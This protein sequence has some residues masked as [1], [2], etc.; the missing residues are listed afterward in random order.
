MNDI[1]WLTMRRMRTPLI[2]LII[3]YVLSVMGMVL[4]PGQDAQGQPIRVGYLDAAYF[5][6]VLA[7]TIGL[8]EVP[9]SFTGAQR[10]Y[11]YLIILPNVVVWLYS[12]GTIL[13]LFLDSQFQAVLHRSRFARKVQRMTQE[14]FVV[15]GLGNTGRMIVRAL[16]QRG[17]QA[18]V[19]ERRQEAVHA[20]A[21]TEEISHVPALA[22]DADDRRLLELAGLH[23]SNCLGII[24]ITNE[25]HA[26]LTIAITGKLLRPELMVLARSETGRVSA[27]MASFGTDYIVDPYAIFA[28]RLFLAFNSPVKYLV[29][30]WLISVPGSV[31]RESLDPPSGHWIL[32]GLGRFGKRVAD[33]LDQAP[34]PYTVIDVHPDRVQER[35]GAVLGRGTEAHSLMEAGIKDAVGIVAATGDDID[36]LSIV[37]TAK[38]LNPRLFVVARQERK[39]NDDLF[40]ASGAD[41]VARRSLIVARR[42]LLM[43]TTPLLPVF[44]QHLLSQGEDFAQRV[45]A[46][47]QSILRGRAPA[48]WTAHLV[49]DMAKGIEEARQIGV[50][51]QLRHVLQHSRSEDDHHLPCVCLLLERGASRIFLPNPAQELHAG[52]RLL[53]AG[54]EEARREIAWSL[55]EP[56][57]LIANATGRIMPRGS[58]WRWLRRRSKSA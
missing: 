14:F 57:A 31:L 2:M 25:D 8:G 56:Y 45:A 43:A 49:T 40:D 48:I 4:I 37:M 12:I 16:L 39:E 21:L 47:L 46:R 30:D 26:N 50:N 18:V 7:T 41:L 23:K 42:I 51:I 33:S 1:I 6:A 28:E 34:L 19:L 5:V 11:V 54:R 24:A 15:C 20:M 32:C 17:Y 36:N 9:I 58:L 38:N 53:F 10:L 52:D 3:V 44:L 13:G 55:S 27:N 29:Q 35:P 22:G